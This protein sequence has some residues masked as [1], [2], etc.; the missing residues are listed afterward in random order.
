MANSVYYRPRQGSNWNALAKNLAGIYEP[1]RSTRRAFSVFIKWQ[2]LNLSEQPAASTEQ[3]AAW[4]RV[5][6]SDC[7]CEIHSRDKASERASG[8]RAL[9]AATLLIK[10]KLS[11]L[12]VK[13]QSFIYKLNGC[14]MEFC[15]T[16]KRD[17][18]RAIHNCCK[19]AFLFLA[20]SLSLS[21]HLSVFLSGQRQTL[22]RLWWHAL[23]VYS[24]L[25]TSTGA[26]AAAAGA[27]GAAAAR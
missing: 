7:I 21:L 5:S 17:R 24:W 22:G 10:N 9:P 18:S 1:G 25:L 23:L 26:T 19:L 15:S 12:T 14:A 4:A 13:R 8:T 6:S 3:W 20:L 16:G 2:K 27:G 11:T